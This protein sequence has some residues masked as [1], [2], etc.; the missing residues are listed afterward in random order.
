MRKIQRLAA[1]GVM[2]A[3]TVALGACGNEEEPAAAPATTAPEAAAPT[4]ESTT[5]ADDG[6][7]EI[8]D[9]TGPAC[10]QVPTSGE[11]SAAGMVDDP[12]ATAAS[13]NPL[14]ETLVAAVTAANLGDT[15]NSAEAITVFAPINSAFEALPPGTVEQLTTAPDAA[16]PTSQLSQILTTHVVG[17]RYDAEGLSSAG[18]VESLQAG[19]ELTIGGTAPDALTVSSGGVTAN[20]VCG[21]VPTANATVFLIDKVMMPAAN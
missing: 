19:S 7:T 17:T 5:A 9:I 14:L 12:V 16:E 10:S 6:V 3:L 4:S 21:N 1:V 2:A 15:L 18:T 11:G 8:Q 13:N 20:V